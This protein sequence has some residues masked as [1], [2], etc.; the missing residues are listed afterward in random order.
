MKT[1]LLLVLTALYSHPAHALVRLDHEFGSIFVN[2]SALC[3]DGD[4][5]RLK[6]KTYD[7]CR[8]DVFSRKTGRCTHKIA[9]V[10][11]RR[12]VTTERVCVESHQG[13]NAPCREFAD[14]QFTL[15]LTYDIIERTGND[16]RPGR[17]IV[18][19]GQIPAC[20]N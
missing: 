20:Q 6:Q 5:V 14:R 19:H 15:P 16:K 18:H 9:V 3:V 4:I 8:E 17:T 7:Y 11:S 2:E 10:P 12:I 1:F 13:K